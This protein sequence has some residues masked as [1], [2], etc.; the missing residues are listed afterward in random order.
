MQA[1]LDRGRVRAAALGHDLESRDT[2][3]PHWVHF[4]RCQQCGRHLGVIRLLDDSTTVTGTAMV[5][6]CEP[7]STAER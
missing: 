1:A 6:P 3:S 2:H 7:G 5:T 4:E